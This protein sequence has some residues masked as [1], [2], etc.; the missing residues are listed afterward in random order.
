[1]ADLTQLGYVPE[2]TEA[3]TGY[4]A[5]PAGEYPAVATEI[6]LKDTK[7]G[8][9]K[10][11]GVEFEIIEGNGK[12]RKVFTNFNLM[13]P[14]PKAVEIGH[15]QLKE[16]ATALGN[17]N[18]KDS[19]ELKNKPVVIKLAIK[20]DPERGAQNEVK[21]YKPYGAGVASAAPAQTQTQPAQTA[22]VNGNKPSWAN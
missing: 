13:N 12:G 2:T 1:M 3:N 9:G 22:Q 20:N 14:N 7:A 5:L 6:E 18:A 17:P 11:L 19:A 4:D 10:Y 16:F 15:A 8:T 21:G